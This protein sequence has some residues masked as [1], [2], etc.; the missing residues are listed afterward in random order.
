MTVNVPATTVCNN[1]LSRAI[2]EKIDV[3][4]MKL[5]KLLYFVACEYIKKTASP[6]FSEAFEVWKYGPVLPSVYNE[7]KS[8]GKEPILTYAKD[9]KG[10]SYI[11]DE[12]AVPDLRLAIDRIWKSFKNWSGVALSQIT[13]KEGS[14]W[15]YSYDRYKTIVES[16]R[17]KED[18]TYEEF[19]PA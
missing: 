17:M 10:I 13:H 15:S 7:F 4:P 6:L 16:D 5:Q 19:M 18:F 12:D 2:N 11:V 3:S 8:Y 1:I 14:A 9:A